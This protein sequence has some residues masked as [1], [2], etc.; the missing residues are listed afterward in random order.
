[1]DHPSQVVVK[2]AG[3]GNKPSNYLFGEDWNWNIF[4]SSL[5]LISF[6]MMG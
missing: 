4:D 5:V 1:M 6:V 2:A 3:E